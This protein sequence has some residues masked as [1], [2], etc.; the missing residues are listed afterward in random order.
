MSKVSSGRKA[1]RKSPFRAAKRRLQHEKRPLP[2]LP[3]T[4]IGSFPQTSDVRAARAAY[5]SGKL[6]TAGYEAFLQKEIERAIR[7]QEEIGLD[8]L[9]HGECKRQ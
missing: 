8:V 9:V 6:D 1:E 3:T 4:T 2:L 5:K 7:F